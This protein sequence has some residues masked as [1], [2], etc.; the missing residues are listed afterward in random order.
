MAKYVGYVTIPVNSYAAWK[1]AVNGNGYDFDQMYGCQCYDLV[2]EFWWNVGFPEGYPTSG[3]TGNAK[4]I[5]TD[6]Y[7]NISYNGTV[8]FDLITDVTKIKVGDIIVFDGFPGNTYGH[9]GFAD[10]AY[11]NWTPDPNE[12]YEFP[13]LSENNGGTPDP[14]GGSYTNVH[15]YDIRL[16]LG[17]F[18]YRPWNPTPPPPTPTGSRGTFPWVL[19]ARKLNEK[20]NGV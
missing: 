16:F 19:Y 11:S 8:Y 14:E 20:R 9:I 4:D 18:R 12:P 15:G 7:N 6:R 5:W 3:G 1:A 10:V 13:I 2:V 17:A